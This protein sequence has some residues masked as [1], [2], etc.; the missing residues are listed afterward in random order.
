M[1]HSLMTCLHASLAASLLAV[2]LHAADIPADGL[3][4]H[5]DASASSV[6]GDAKGGRV[7]QWK[8]LS[9]K[10][11]HVKADDESRQPF[12]VPKALNGLP[13]VRFSGEEYLDGPAVLSEGDSSLTI[14]AV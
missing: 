7:P 3:A 9:G 11:H 14:V 1:S 4:L 12:L 6:A 5:L 2:S 10:G 13:V 8:D